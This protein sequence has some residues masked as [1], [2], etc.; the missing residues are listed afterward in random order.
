MEFDLIIVTHD[1]VLVIELKN[2]RGKLTSYDGNWYIDGKYRSKSPYH[3]KRDQALR[4]KNILQTHLSHD[5][6][7]VP[8]VEAHVVLCGRRPLI[9][10]HPANSSTSTGW[11]IS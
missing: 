8:F 4:L 2:W 11:M 1:R 10:C 7:Y 9:I 3:T 5:L 6:G